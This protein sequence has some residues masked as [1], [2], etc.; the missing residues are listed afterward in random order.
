MPTLPPI[1]VFRLNPDATLIDLVLLTTSEALRRRGW[2]TDAFEVDALGFPNELS[3][4]DYPI[5]LR[6]QGSPT[7]LIGGWLPE[8]WFDDNQELEPAYPS[9][10]EI[11][12]NSLRK[13]QQVWLK[14]DESRDAQGQLVAGIL[15]PRAARLT[16][17][18]D[19]RPAPPTELAA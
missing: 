3:G 15:Q 16:P 7:E 10:I 6:L 1:P 9:N 11:A 14:A 8:V 12:C 5:V 17:M 4:Q 19:N 18:K 13:V 2:E